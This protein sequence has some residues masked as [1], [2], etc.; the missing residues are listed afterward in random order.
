MAT[1]ENAP[2]TPFDERNIEGKVVLVVGASKG[3]GEEVAVQI[4]KRKA[5]LIVCARTAPN[6]MQI[7][8]KSGAT[9]VMSFACDIGKIDDIRAL[10]TNIKANVDHLDA[11]ILVASIM[12]GFML[13]MSDTSDELDMQCYR[14]NMEGYHFVT[15]YALPLLNAAPSGFERTIIYITA[16]LGWLSEPVPGL[17]AVGYSAS[18]AAENALC[19][20]VHKQYVEDSPVAIKIRGNVKLHRVAS[21]HPGVVA[22]G[23]GSETAAGSFG[24]SPDASYEEVLKKRR[25]M[26]FI[27]IEEGADTTLWLLLA[28]DGVVKSGSHYFERKVHSY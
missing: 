3:I 20:R 9:D 26:G 1:G 27:P 12:P 25:D 8:S 18:K 2:N 24:L 11:V 7:K 14:I 15:K 6:A 16:A 19:V 23:L 28:K 4:A 17:G 21:V 10:F 5:K 13:P 22:S